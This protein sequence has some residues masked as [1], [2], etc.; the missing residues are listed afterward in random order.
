MII[1]AAK[2]AFFYENKASLPSDKMEAWWYFW[3]YLC[4]FTKQN[5]I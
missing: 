5:T 4:T 1:K 3:V 2:L